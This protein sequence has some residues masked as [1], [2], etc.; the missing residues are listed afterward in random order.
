LLPKIKPQL[1]A[2]SAERINAGQA[3]GVDREK[4]SASAQKISMQNLRESAVH[5]PMMGIV[6][7]LWMNLSHNRNTNLLAGSCARDWRGCG[8]ICFRSHE[9]NAPK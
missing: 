3:G 2:Y 9:K 6:F 4:H 5:V 7:A 8:N 1:G